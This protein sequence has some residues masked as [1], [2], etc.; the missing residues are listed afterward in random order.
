M[1]KHLYIQ[2][3]TMIQP[4]KVIS[5]VC[6]GSVHGNS[7]VGFGGESDGTIDPA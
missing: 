3:A 7:G 5:S 6:V 4:M 1:K 2:P